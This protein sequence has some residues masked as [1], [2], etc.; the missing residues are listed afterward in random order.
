MLTKKSY[1]SEIA[2]PHI[3]PLQFEWTPAIPIVKVINVINEVACSFSQ[4]KSNEQVSQW[5]LSISALISTCTGHRWFTDTLIRTTP[6]VALPWG[7]AGGGA[8]NAMQWV[9]GM[10]IGYKNNLLSVPSLSLSFPTPHLSLQ[11]CLLALPQV[12]FI[13]GET[14][15][16]QTAPTC[17]R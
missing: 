15:S 7:N 17:G 14:S 16:S 9:E 2:T 3:Q 12:R 4:S 13:P 8:P 5:L 6:R 11:C 1:E 10:G